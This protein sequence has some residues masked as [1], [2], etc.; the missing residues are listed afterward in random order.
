MIMLEAKDIHVSYDG[1]EALKGISLHVGK[2]SIVSIIGPNGAGKTT[3]LKTI[4]GGKKPTVGEIWYQKRRID[5]LTTEEIIG[6]RMA[7]VPEGRR[8]FPHLTVLENLQ[9]GAYLLKDKKVVQTNLGIVSKL[10]PIL[11]A[12]K[13]QAGGSLSGGEQ[14]ML[15]IG[16][17]LMS[18]PELVLM[19]EPTLGLSP[20]VCQ[21]LA[22]IINSLNKEQGITILLVEQNAKMALN[23]GTWGYV[24]EG[25]KIALEDTCEHLRKNERVVQIYLGQ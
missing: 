12:R 14:Q 21:N 9:M 16:R 22:V 23:L 19:D 3:T 1:L 20:I 5:G 7:L 4:C 6:L 17:A 24:L 8:I 10:F 15:A 18:S 13:R 2:G 25:G 11:E